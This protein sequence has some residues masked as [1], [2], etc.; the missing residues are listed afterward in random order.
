[1]TTQ[2]LNVLVLEGTPGAA[3]SACD[4]LRAAGHTVLRC[5][6]PHA[7]AFPCHGIADGRTCPLDGQAVDVALD[8]RSTPHPQA[9]PYEDGVRCAIHAHVPVVVAGATTL[10]PY[11]PYA[12]AVV[13]HLYDVVESC[14]R[15]AHAPLRRH[16]AV[17]ER[18][19]AEV[20]RTHGVEPSDATVDVTRDRGALGI[21]VHG[22]DLLDRQTKNI[23]AA[24]II[25]AVRA[26]D[27]SATKIDVRFVD[28]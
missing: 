22:A 10:K 2:S 7:S 27:R 15:A 20:L 23:A 16:G 1:M 18:V 11:E 26:L 28:V 4:E 25:G 24:R 5:H 21:E 14:E 13:D 12:A 6:D 17:A 8:V 9:L 19:L 3:R